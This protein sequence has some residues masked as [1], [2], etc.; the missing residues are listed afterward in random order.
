MA[1]EN[2]VER[3][4]NAVTPVAE[5]LAARAQEV[6]KAATEVEKSIETAVRESKPVVQLRKA[7]APAPAKKAAPKKAQAKRAP[8]KKAA[9][10][11]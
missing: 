1:T 5:N 10:K 9:K 6:V 11:K 2:L 8:A 4:K 3:V 7:L